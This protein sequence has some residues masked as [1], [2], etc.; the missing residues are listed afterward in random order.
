[1]TRPVEE[2]RQESERSR[3]ELA[4]AVD[5]LR[6]QIIGTAEDIRHKVSPQHVKSEISEFITHKTRGWA[7]SLKQ[8]A[9]QNPMQAVAAGAFVA[10][11]MLRL[12]RGF[13]LPL[14]MVGAGLALTSKTVRDKAA[15]TASPLIDRGREM[16][17]DAA[18]QASSL[19]RSAVDTVSSVRHGMMGEAQ[20]A[21]VGMTDKFRSR[22]AETSGT[23]KDTLRS[24]MDD[25]RSGQSRS[26]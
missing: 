25:R 12:A 18:D 19:G 23:V 7:E 16:M 4:A 17:H 3:A 1:M 14:L 11:P 26:K 10:V 21:A 22:A 2:L 20:D 6:E 15:E 13:S 24:S 8:R 9:V 5:D